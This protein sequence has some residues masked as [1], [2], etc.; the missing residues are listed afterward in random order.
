VGSVQS[1]TKPTH[2]NEKY[3]THFRN[4]WSLTWLN[5]SYGSI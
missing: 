4:I 3:D 5:S 2:T 1:T